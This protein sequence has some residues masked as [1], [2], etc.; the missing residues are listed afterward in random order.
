MTDSRRKYIPSGMTIPEEAIDEFI[1]I[2]K[3]EFRANISGEEA[4]RRPTNMLAL[5]RAVLD[6]NPKQKIS[7]D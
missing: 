1:E 6:E 7:E 4:R 3:R 5:Y 2:Y